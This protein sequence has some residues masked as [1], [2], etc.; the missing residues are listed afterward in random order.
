MIKTT[1]KDLDYLNKDYSGRSM[2]MIREKERELDE[3]LGH[4]EA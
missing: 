3:L 1:Q 4:E 2:E